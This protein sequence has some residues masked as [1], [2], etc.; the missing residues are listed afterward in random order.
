MSKEEDREINNGI[1]CTGL[2][3]AAVSALLALLFPSL[4]VV[5]VLM[6]VMYVAWVLNTVRAMRRDAG[7]RQ[8]SGL[9]GRS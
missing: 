4:R 1:I 2:S 9:F 8:P 7:T 5:F 3:G 6:L